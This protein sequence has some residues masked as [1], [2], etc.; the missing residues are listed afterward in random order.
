MKTKRW[1]AYLQLL[2]FPDGLPFVLF[3]S[4]LGSL[5]SDSPPFLSIALSL[6]ANLAV[7]CFAQIYKHICNAPGDTFSPS[8][9]DPNPISQG[10]VSLHSAR[11]GLYLVLILSLISAFMLSRMNIVLVSSAIVL[12]LALFNPN[13]RLS[14]RP[15]LGFTQRHFLYSAIFFLGS[16][17]ANPART[18]LV[19]VL[20]PLLFMIS[21]YLLYRVEE[22]RAENSQ[23][24]TI[25]FWR[26]MFA[27][28]I[29]VFG[30]VTFFLL[31]PLP[32]WVIGLW[33]FLVAIQLTVKH[34]FQPDPA[35]NQPL[36]LLKIFEVS[37]V[38]SFL[39]YLIS[40]FFNTY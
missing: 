17:F 11:I 33:V 4:L 36:H 1:T 15:M 10:T 26:I 39:I 25:S 38:V 19:E 18:N 22:I 37:G 35:P 6:A 20:F 2:G 34:S 29:L 30:L 5:V 32:F 28:A 40:V 14:D 8:A 21:F 13:I 23:Q 31:R 3:C 7:F 12:T 9:F 16:V 27:T 24:Q